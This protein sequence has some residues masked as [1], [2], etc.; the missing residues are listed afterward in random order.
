M[1]KQHDAP[2]PA[3]LA[4]GAPM[5]NRAALVRI[6]PFAAYLA[7]IALAELLVRLGWTATELRWLY[8][9]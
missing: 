4:A 5:F 1:S 6:L 7:F 8:A 9:A 3:A 2:S